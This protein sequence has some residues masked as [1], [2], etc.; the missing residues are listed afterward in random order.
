MSSNVCD[1]CE[2][3]ASITVGDDYY[4]S[5]CF[6]I[7]ENDELAEKMYLYLKTLTNLPEA[8]E[9]VREYEEGE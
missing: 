9:L 8:V 1:K 3:R 6:D 2:D 5:R 7:V 4:C